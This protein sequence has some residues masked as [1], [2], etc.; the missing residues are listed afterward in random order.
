MSEGKDELIKAL[1]K[2]TLEFDAIIKDGDA[3]VITKAGGKYGYGYAT[4]DNII[5]ATKKGLADNGLNIRH[6]NLLKEDGKLWLVSELRHE[7]GCESDK[8]ESPIDKFTV[9][10]YMSAIQSFGSVITYLKRYHMG[11]L[12]N[13]AIDEDD[14]GKSGDKGKA[15][16]KKAEPEKPKDTPPEQPANNPLKTVDEAFAGFQ[17]RIN[18][19]DNIFELKGYGKKHSADI[20]ALPAEQYQQIRTLYASRESSLNLLALA[21]KIGVSHFDLKAYLA[22]LP[23]PSLETEAM[24]GNADAI[25]QITAEVKEYIKARME[26]DSERQDNNNLISDEEQENAKYEQ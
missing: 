3:Q 9:E 18:E 22:G 13:L 10:G 8:T 16:Q 21:Q 25:K 1:T 20:K 14:D 6:Y 4:L 15:N 7:S 19:I 17:K 2:A 24:L 12:L 5:R 23:D 11:E 26:K